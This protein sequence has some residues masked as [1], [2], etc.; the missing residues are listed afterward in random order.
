MRVPV[1]FWLTV[2]VPTLASRH[3]QGLRPPPSSGQEL[4]PENWFT[5]RLDHFK[6]T[7]TRTWQQRYWINWRYYKPGGPALLMIGGE[8]EANPQWLEAG[9]WLDYARAEGAAMLLL[10]HRYYGNSHPTPDL[11][12]KN[13]KWLS[14]RQAL[15]DLAAFISQQ[16]VEAGLAGAWVALGGSYPGSLAA[17]LRLKY[18]HLVAGAVSSSGPLQAKA[19]FFEYLEV[20]EAA[21]DTV[22]GCSAV[23]KSAIKKVEKLTAHRMGWKFLSKHFKL[24]S[25]LDG[26][27]KYDVTNL[28][29]S[30]IGNF[31]GI[32]QYNKDNRAFEGAEWQ[33]V[34]IDTVCDIMTDDSQGSDLQRLA[35]VND[36]SLKMSDE[37]CLDHTYLSEV[38]R[39]LHQSLKLTTECSR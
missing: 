30:L 5:Q 25:S 15:A 23:V 22:P 6:I 27:N 39:A 9:A 12:V 28:F 37:K 32:V 29:E 1:L 13:L 17:W 26:G 18:P 2:S 8:G 34:T 24:C 19:D 36:L 38:S 11:T 33:N 20:V 21:L 31:E 7:D 35:L 3:L 14:S 4:P 10:E 16:R